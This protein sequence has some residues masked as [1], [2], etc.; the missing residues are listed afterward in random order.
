MKMVKMS[1]AKIMHIL[2]M[3]TLRRYRIEKEREW[4]TFGGPCKI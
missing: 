3:H 2:P 4:D 1:D